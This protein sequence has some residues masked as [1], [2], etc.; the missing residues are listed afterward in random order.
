MEELREREEK[1]WQLL[2]LL[3]FLNVLLQEKYHSNGHFHQGFLYLWEILVACDKN[4]FQNQKSDLKD[5]G[6]RNLLVSSSN[7][8]T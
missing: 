7:T 4:T 1:E 3:R 5:C 6:W 8:H 2:K